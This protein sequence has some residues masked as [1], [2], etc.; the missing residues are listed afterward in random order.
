MVRQAVRQAHGPERSRRT[1]HPEHSRRGIQRFYNALRYWMPVDDPVFSGD[2]VR[3]DRLN[4]DFF[5]LL[6][7][8]L[9]YTEEHEQFRRK[10]RGFCQKKIIPNVRKWEK[11]GL[12][13]KA[14]WQMLA[15]NTSKHF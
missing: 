8:L 11:D 2:Q 1:H 7:E 12:V 15:L 5:E 9:H 13:P 14:V 4:K 6:M 10:L 3:H